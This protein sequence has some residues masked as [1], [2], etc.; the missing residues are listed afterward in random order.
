M[1]FF[2]RNRYAL[3]Y[4]LIALALFC[5]GAL[6]IAGCM[7]PARCPTKAFH[8]QPCDHGQRDGAMNGN[9]CLA[10]ATASDQSF[11]GAD[12]AAIPAMNIDPGLPVPTSVVRL[13][14]QSPIDDDHLVAASPPIPI[15]YCSL[16]N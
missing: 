5:Q 16:R 9:L 13:G 10:H 1:R 15:R 7:S 2:H 4:M 14:A 11:D 3:A 8:A 6:A 12:T